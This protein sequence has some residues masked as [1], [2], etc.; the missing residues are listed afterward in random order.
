M[1]Q[2]FDQANKIM[3]KKLGKIIKSIIK[4]MDMFKIK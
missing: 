2:Q 1:E 4:W 3:E